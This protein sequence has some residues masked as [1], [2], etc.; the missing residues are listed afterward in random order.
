MPADMT[1]CNCNPEF[2]MEQV[3]EGKTK[4]A[5]SCRLLPLGAARALATGAGVLPCRLWSLG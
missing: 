2:L 3:T 1:S 4:M 5:G